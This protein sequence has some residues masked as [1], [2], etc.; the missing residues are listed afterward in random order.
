[1][2][3]IFNFTP[4]SLECNKNTGVSGSLLFYVNPDPS[5]LAKI[6]DFTPD[7]QLPSNFQICGTGESIISDFKK[8]KMRWSVSAGFTAKSRV[9]GQKSTFIKAKTLEKMHG[10]PQNTKVVMDLKFQNEGS[11]NSLYCKLYCNVITV[12]SK[13]F[14]GFAYK[15]AIFLPKRLL[16]KLLTFHFPLYI[17]SLWGIWIILLQMYLSELWWLV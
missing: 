15:F 16:S 12:C 8:K 6:L 14:Y 7:T 9:S 17:A 11:I 4:E 3:L 5:N 2:L 13:C 10:M 1:M